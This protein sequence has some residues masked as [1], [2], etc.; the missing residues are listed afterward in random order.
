MFDNVHFTIY[1]RFSK[2]NFMTYC[3]SSVPK[4]YRLA[5]HI[6]GLLACSAS[7]KQ[8]DEVV[9]SA[10]V[11]FCSPATG[12]NVTKH[13]KNLQVLMQQMGTM[14]VEE[15]NIIAEDYKVHLSLTQ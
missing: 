12:H 5:M 4:H 15:Q 13:Y 11:L 14:D 9:L 10:T 8:M 2:I 7:L 1:S 3:L 6:I